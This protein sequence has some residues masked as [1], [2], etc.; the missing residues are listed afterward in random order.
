LN[1]ELLSLIVVISVSMAISVGLLC[2]LMFDQILNRTIEKF[3]VKKIPLMKKKKKNKKDEQKDKITFGM[4]LGCASLLGIITIGSDIFMFSI[5]A[6]IGIGFIGSKIIIKTFYS[7][8]KMVKLKEVSLLYESID[9]FTHAGFTVRQALQISKTLLP[10]LKKPID[11]CLNNWP[12]GSLKAIEEFGAE[13]SEDLPEAD[14]LTGLL[15]QA[16]EGG[17]ENITGIMEQEAIRLEDLR[18]AAAE[19]KIAIE[20]IF[21]AIY[22]FLPVASVLGIIMAP[23]AYRAIEMLTNIRAGG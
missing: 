16:E 8:N 14:V 4:M 12:S 19:T 2:Y 3:K 21:S 22:M 15:M 6:G 20:P 17:I 11:K 1:Y 23:L 10:N 7:K 13:I 9:L 18:K 5:P